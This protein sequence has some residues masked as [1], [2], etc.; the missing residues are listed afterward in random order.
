MAF[1]ADAD[2]DPMVNVQG[3]GTATLETVG[4][5][6]HT[7]EFKLDRSAS[8]LATVSINGVTLLTDQP[9]VPA[10]GNKPRFIYFGSWSGAAIGGAR[11]NE[12]AFSAMCT[13]DGDFDCDGDRD[14]SDF[15]VWQRGESPSLL[16]VGDYDDWEANFGAP[17]TA[18]AVVSI[19]EPSTLLLASL[20]GLFFGT[21]RR[22]F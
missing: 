7:F 19:P 11:Y 3:G 21:R 14:G 10:E 20:A 17:A 22:R 2:G 13:L 15:L 12:V 16:G 5:G 8:S 9:S 6:Y 1:G 18:A 4:S